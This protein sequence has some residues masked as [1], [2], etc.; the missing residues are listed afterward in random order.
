MLL[1]RGHFKYNMNPY[2]L[3]SAENSEHLKEFMVF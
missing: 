3:T 1:L 2:L